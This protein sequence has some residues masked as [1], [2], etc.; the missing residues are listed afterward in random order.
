[1]SDRP[2]ACCELFPFVGHRTMLEAIQTEEMLAR[3]HLGGNVLPKAELPWLYDLLRRKRR[4][5]PP[6]E[7]D[8][9]APAEPA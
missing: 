1:M 7:I 8:A 6:S 2:R 3:L 9:R 4:N 5:N